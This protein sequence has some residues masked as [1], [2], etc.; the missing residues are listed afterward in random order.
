M[1]T[2]SVIVNETVTFAVELEAQ[3]EEEAIAL[4]NEDINKYEIVSEKVTDWQVD[5]AEEV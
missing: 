5:Y 4:V 1:P 2:Y 3:S